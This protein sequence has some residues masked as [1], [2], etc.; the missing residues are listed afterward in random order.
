MKKIIKYVLLLIIVLT[1]TSCGY[2][3]EEKIELNTKL[4]KSQK[5]QK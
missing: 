1:V 4:N 2:T 3:K 5:F